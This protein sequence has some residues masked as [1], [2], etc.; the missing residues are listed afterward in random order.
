MLSGVV[1]HLG[2]KI[3]SGPRAQRCREKNK[4]RAGGDHPPGKSDGLGAV[5]R[6]R[7]R[8]QMPQPCDGADMIDIGKRKS[9]RINGA[10]DPKPPCKL[11]LGCAH[12]IKI[13]PLPGEAEGKMSISEST[14]SSD[15]RQ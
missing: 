1:H 5:R 2:S 8:N 11:K 12:A 14:V 6:K 13:I 3:S 4:E 7:R 10:N 15:V 9:R